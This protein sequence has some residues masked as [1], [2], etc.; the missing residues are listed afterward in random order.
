ME[1]PASREAAQ[2]RRLDVGNVAR[3][4]SPHAITD[5]PDRVVRDPP[6]CRE[7]GFEPS[8]D[9]VDQTEMA[10]LAAGVSPIDDEH[11]ETETRKML[12]KAALR[13]EIENIVAVN[14]RANDQT[15]GPLV[16]RP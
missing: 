5:N 2:D 11:L 16:S 7:S 12:Q 6:R 3:A 14:Q 8:G 9:V 15:V 13:Q 4:T 10:L 1:I